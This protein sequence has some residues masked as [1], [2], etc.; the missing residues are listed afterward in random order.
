MIRTKREYTLLGLVGLMLLALPV[1]WAARQLDRARAG[2]LDAERAHQAMLG[3]ASEFIALRDQERTVQDGPVL[4]G[5]V[6]ARAQLVLQSAGLDPRRLRSTTDSAPTP[7][8]DSPYQRQV[9]TITIDELSATDA[10]RV[11]TEWR[12]AEPSWTVRAV[13]L[14][15]AATGR[16]T[17]DAPTL[18]RFSLTLTL[19]S[20]HL[21]SPPQEVSS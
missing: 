18:E 10:A 6:H 5:D 12:A 21:A 14:D 4:Q 9:A 17:S 15:H 7:I 8:K 20:V 19:E 16:R 11:L 13:R 1:V 3:E 2:H